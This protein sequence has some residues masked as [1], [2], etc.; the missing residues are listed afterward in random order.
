MAR[1]VSKSGSECGQA[2]KMSSTYRKWVRVMNRYFST[3]TAVYVSH[4]LSMREKEPT[5][6][7]TVN[8]PHSTVAS[9]V[10]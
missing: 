1:N 10:L 5:N 8:V 7:T 9:T 4:G 3:I 2:P 6:V